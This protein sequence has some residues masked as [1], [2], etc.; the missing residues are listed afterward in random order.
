[1]T[2]KLITNPSARVWIKARGC[3]S[4]CRLKSVPLFQSAVQSRAP[5][6]SLLET[7]HKM[8]AR[9]RHISRRRALGA[10]ARSQQMHVVHHRRHRDVPSRGRDDGASPGAAARQ[11]CPVLVA[12]C[13]ALSR[14]W[15]AVA[16]KTVPGNGAP[17][18]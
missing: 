5:R 1:M 13:A 2:R 14:G 9:P 4:P 7:Q 3:P 15:V 10:N 18:P 11:D 6:S 12:T 17:T 16:L 8:S